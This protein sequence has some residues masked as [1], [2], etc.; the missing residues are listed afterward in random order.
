[1]A[2]PVLTEVVTAWTSAAQTHPQPG[3]YRKVACPNGPTRV[4][5]W[6]VNNAHYFGFVRTVSKE[7]WHWEYKGESGNRFAISMDHWSW[8]NFF[9]SGLGQVDNPT[10]LAVL[11]EL[12]TSTPPSDGVEDSGYECAEEA[13]V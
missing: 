8:D 4:Y 3:D 1:M 10:S 5:E 11:R 13:T 12:G 9:T 7:R 2:Q 6:L